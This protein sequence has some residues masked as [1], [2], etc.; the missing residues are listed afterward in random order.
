MIVLTLSMPMPIPFPSPCLSNHPLLWFESSVGLLLLHNL[1]PILPSSDISTHQKLSHIPL[2]LS[3]MSIPPIPPQANLLSTG[4]WLLG[5][6]CLVVGVTHIPM[7]GTQTSDANFV[8][9][10]SLILVC[11]VWCCYPFESLIITWRPLLYLYSRGGY[12]GSN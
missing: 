10:S 8:L 7:N 2:L 1:I 3:K 6:I 9:Y 12:R 4:G 5:N 11:D